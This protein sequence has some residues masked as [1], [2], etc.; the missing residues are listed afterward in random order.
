[1][2]NNRFVEVT[3]DKD[4]VYVKIPIDFMILSQMNRDDMPFDIVNEERMRKWIEMNFTEF[5]E[6]DIYD[7]DNSKNMTKVTAFER[8]LDAM[9]LCAYVYGETWLQGIVPEEE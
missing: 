2:N 6:K 1:M 7:N 8:Y 9:F 5:Y 4:N 3:S